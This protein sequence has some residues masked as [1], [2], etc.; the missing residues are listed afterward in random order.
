MR[1]KSHFRS[2]TVRQMKVKAKTTY[3]LYPMPT[4][5]NFAR[6]RRIIRWKKRS[7]NSPTSPS[8]ITLS[9][10]RNQWQATYLANNTVINPNFYL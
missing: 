5:E 10:R 3:A 4:A 2:R 6:S 1:N 9:R 7:E 8:K